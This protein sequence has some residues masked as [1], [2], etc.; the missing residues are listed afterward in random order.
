MENLRRIFTFGP[1]WRDYDIR[2]RSYEPPTTGIFT[3]GPDWRDYDSVRNPHNRWKRSRFLPL[4]LIEGITTGDYP[5]D[6]VT[7]YSIFTFGPDWRDY[8][9]TSPASSSANLPDFYLW[10]WLKGLRPPAQS[11]K[12]FHK[13]HRI[14]TFGPDWRDYDPQYLVGYCG[15]Y[16]VI[17]LPLDLI[18]GITTR[19]AGKPARL[20]PSRI[21]TFGPDWRD[22]DLPNSTLIGCCWENG[23]LPLD[24]IEGITTIF[25]CGEL[26]TPDDPFLPLDL[27]EGITT[28]QQSHYQSKL[29]SSIF[30]FGPDWRDYDKTSLRSWWIPWP[31]FL[32]LD[33][34]EGITTPG[35]NRKI[36]SLIREFL[37]LDLIEGI[38]TPVY[39]SK[40]PIV[41][42]NFYLWTWL[43]GLRHPRALSTP[44]TGGRFLPLDLIEGITTSCSRTPFKYRYVRFLPLDLIEGITTALSR[45]QLSTPA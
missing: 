19:R 40:M 36:L 4:D 21:F 26:A 24:L 2:R 42:G 17:F 38:T 37:P 12:F 27:I 35:E 41:I 34:I 28:W 6:P 20:K 32:P 23:F 9:T 29:L 3:F 45:G 1:D 10:T 33:L 11:R 43:K 18:E 7:P 25:V 8:D 14:F 30:T 15:P 44:I 13:V 22:Y 31:E 5:V 16:Y 39:S